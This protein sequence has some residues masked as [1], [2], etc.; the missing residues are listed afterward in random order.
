MGLRR[1]HDIS[2]AL[3]KDLVLSPLQVLHADE[4]AQF[5]PN[6]PVIDGR[7]NVED[8]ELC[9]VPARQ[10]AGHLCRPFSVLERSKATNI[11]RTPIFPPSLQ[12]CDNCVQ[13]SGC[14]SPE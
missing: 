2:T 11:I 1:P 13:T 8:Q 7:H 12:G 9:L 5:V 14:S 3:L 10:I 6:S 4:I